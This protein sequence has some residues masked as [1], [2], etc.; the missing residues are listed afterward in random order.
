[1]KQYKSL[2][3]LSCV[4]AISLLTSCK[5]VNDIEIT[6][7]DGFEF[8]G[9]ENNSLTFSANIG[10]RNPSSLNFRLKE[11]NLKTVIDGNFLGILST[12]DKIR[13]K[14]RSD[15]SYRMTFNLQLNNIL[16][17]A[18]MLY[19]LSRKKDVKVEMQGYIKAR[20]FIAVKKVDVLESRVVEVPGNF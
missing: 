19:D 2:I 12:S 8:K 5:G 10:V 16:T 1:M 11:I 15:S 13:V 4:I 6:G 9:M 14:A 7:A 18:S 20:S 3:F 17:G